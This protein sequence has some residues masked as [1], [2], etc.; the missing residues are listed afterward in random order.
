MSLPP[1]LSGLAGF[2]DD[3]LAAFA[4]P[5]LVRRAIKLVTDGAV[6][7]GD[8]GD[9][10][11]EV[12]CDGLS[13]RLAPGG[14]KALRC[15]CPVAGVCVHVVASCLWA[16]SAVDILS[17]S[18]DADPAG[19]PATAGTEPSDVLS[20]VLA[21]TP[22]SVNRAAGMA[23]IRRVAREPL[24][25]PNTVE[26]KGS[27][28]T[29][30]WPGSPRVL[31][32]AGVGPE[33]MVVEGSHSDV[34]ER[35]W[36]LAAVVRLFAAHG[37]A[38]SWPDGLAARDGLQP[39]QLHAASEVAAVVE[40]LTA[41]GLARAAVGAADRLSRAG[42]RAKLEDLPLLARLTIAAAS[43]VRALLARDDDTHESAAFSALAQ[44]WAL[45][46]AIAS[47]NTPA[48]LMGGSSG[49]DEAGVRRLIPL[50][51]RWW[52]ATS[53]A[54]GLTL[55][56]WDPDAGRLEQATTGRAA[57]ADPSF[58]ASWVTPLLW[59]ASAE[60][61]C[62]GPLEVA[63]AK[64][65]DD[66][67]LSATVRTSVTAGTWAGVDLDTL[68]A[69]VNAAGEGAA[70]VMF[71]ASSEL[72]RVIRPRASFG[73]GTIELDEVSQRLIWPVVDTAG[74]V[75]RLTLDAG[76]RN[77]QLL[78]WLIG[79]ARIAAIVAVGDQPEGIFLIENKAL[80]L[81]SLTLTPLRFHGLSASWRRILLGQG[82][83]RRATGPIRELDDLQRLC[84]SVGDVA[85]ALA[86]SGRSTLTD[87]QTETLGRRRREAS[88]LGLGSLT[89]ALEPLTTGQSKASDLLRL[90]FVLDRLETLLS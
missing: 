43:E 18:A 23:A 54:R 42:T 47:D 65:R 36:R 9:E 40:R 26:A 69:E 60:R 31:A 53:G 62:A 58:T 50:A 22:E 85:L 46:T 72:V 82:K 61:L 12:A 86:S 14:P 71:G 57:G 17:D 20:E 51:A 76:E 83:E 80:K 70:R 64:R 21:W 45:G 41:D 32:I 4:N 66:G 56:A 44:A 48:T 87:R 13:V 16:R 79:R 35:A 84:A 28:L 25:G 33:G 89:D 37:R 63:A 24:D 55:H 73:L 67:T 77:S 59:G 15:P 39:A 74:R 27:Q 52:Q 34:A 38:W 10:W 49:Q 19:V 90:R 11:V 7:L 2:D 81:I 3:A 1:W 6:T 75:H 68:A 5:G 88:D 78:T 8:M 30:S 29:L